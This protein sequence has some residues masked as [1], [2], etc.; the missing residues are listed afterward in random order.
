MAQAKALIFPAEEED[1]GITPVE[2]MAVGTPVIALKSGGVIESVIDGK[3]GLFFDE[4]T[5]E[6]LIKTIKEFERMKIKPED[7]I[8]QTRKFSKD[9]FKKQMLEFITSHARVA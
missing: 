1:F 2:A 7:C 5:V 3:T 9:R 8:N 4:S 6:S